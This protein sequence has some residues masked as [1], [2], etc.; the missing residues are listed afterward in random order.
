MRYHN[1]MFCCFYSY[2]PL[3]TEIY[4]LKWD[5]NYVMGSSQT[6]HKAF[7][8][9]NAIYLSLLSFPLFISPERESSSDRDLETELPCNLS[10][11]TPDYT[12][13]S[14]QIS[15]LTSYLVFRRFSLSGPSVDFK[16][17]YPSPSP[18]L[19]FDV[20]YHLI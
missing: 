6:K 16:K 13:L 5:P 9:M 19:S 4:K 7:K 15:K 14:L 18:P 17:Y 10:V 11:L 1:V 8:V 3:S 2:F 20:R 12:E